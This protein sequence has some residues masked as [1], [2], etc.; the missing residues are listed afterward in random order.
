MA[1]SQDVLTRFVNVHWPEPA[2]GLAPLSL[3]FSAT[4]TGLYKDGTPTVA[5][6]SVEGLPLLSPNTFK[7]NL[8]EG[9][10]KPPFFTEADYGGTTDLT[11]PDGSGTLTANWELAQHFGGAAAGS[12]RYRSSG[13]E[14]PFLGQKEISITV[15]MQLR[16]LDFLSSTSQDNHYEWGAGAVAGIPGIPS[17]EQSMS[18]SGRAETGETLTF[19]L[20]VIMDPPS[21]TFTA[22]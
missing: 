6:L 18:K 16:P 9:F 13:A 19:T 1:Y 14:T 10:T 12:V 8:P 22:G 2:A 7:V 17:D 11:M 20:S 21:A 4:P 5:T 3:G 15:V